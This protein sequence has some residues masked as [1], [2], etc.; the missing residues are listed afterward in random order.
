V[1]REGE[2]GKGCSAGYEPAAHVVEDHIPAAA[3]GPADRAGAVPDARPAQAVPELPRLRLDE[4]LRELLDRAQEVI[5]T[6]SRLR[7]LLDAVIAVGSDLSL[8]VVLRRI[9]EAACRLV[10][11]R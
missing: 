1:R 9:A 2:R 5:A 6:Q 10:D 11:A 7:G 8:P 3:P 4:L